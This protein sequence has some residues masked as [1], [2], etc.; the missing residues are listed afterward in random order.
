MWYLPFCAV[1]SSYWFWNWLDLFTILEQLTILHAGTF[2][3]VRSILTWFYKLSMGHGDGFKV[4]YLIAWPLTC[5]CKS[6]KTTQGGRASREHRIWTANSE[7]TLLN[8]H[9]RGPMTDSQLK[10]IAD[11]QTFRVFRFAWPSSL[12]LNLQKL[13]RFYVIAVWVTSAS[14]IKL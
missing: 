9:P 6:L 2:T 13:Y 4:I 5:C 3:Y 1:E 8:E 10:R 11:K 7:T 12:E 14:S